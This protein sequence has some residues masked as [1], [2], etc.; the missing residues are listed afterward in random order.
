MSIKKYRDV[1]EVPPPPASKRRSAE[2]SLELGYGLAALSG[3]GP[4]VRGLFKYRSLEEAQEH[5]AALEI[6]RARRLRAARRAERDG[7]A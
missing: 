4:L 2:Q 5:R 3:A 1:S 7:S 6:A